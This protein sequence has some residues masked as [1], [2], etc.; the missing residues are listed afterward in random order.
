VVTLDPSLSPDQT[1]PLSPADQERLQTPG[2]YSEAVDVIGQTT[3]YVPNLPKAPGEKTEPLADENLEM[4]AEFAPALPVSPSV[5]EKAEVT[6]EPAGPATARDRPSGA[7]IYDVRRPRNEALGVLDRIGRFQIR[8]LLGEGAFGRVY[9]AYDPQLDREVALKVPK[10]SGDKDRAGQQQRF[11]REAQAAARLRHAGIVIVYDSGAAGADL[12]IACEYVEG[13]SLATVMAKGRPKIRRAAQWVRDMAKAL[14]Y[15]HRQ[16]LIHRDIKPGNI[17]IDQQGKPRLMDFGLAKRL[18]GTVAADQAGPASDDALWTRQGNI[19]GTPAYMA[20]EQAR[21][22]A[23]AVGRHSDQFSLGVV[24]YELLTGARPY[25]GGSVYEV[26]C[27]LVDPKAKP[28]RPRTLEPAIPP[29]LEAICLKALTREP[30]R[31][32][33]SCGDL[34]EDLSCWLAGKPVEAL[35]QG[36]LVRLREW[37]RRHRP[38]AIASG[39]AAASLLLIAMLVFGLTAYWRHL[40]GVARENEER[41]AELQ[42]QEKAQR[43]LA[44][45]AECQSLRQTG[46]TRCGNQRIPEG[47]LL[48]ARAFAKATEVADETL[49]RPV[50]GDLREWLGQLDEPAALKPLSRPGWAAVSRLLG[51]ALKPEAGAADDEDKIV[52]LLGIPLARERPVELACFSADGSNVLAATATSWRWWQAATG[53]S[54]GSVQEYRARALTPDGTKVLATNGAAEAPTLCLRDALSGEALGASFMGRSPNDTIY[55]SPDGGL[56]VIVPGEGFANL[57]NTVTGKHLE[58][59]LGKDWRLSGLAFSQDGQWLLGSWG[60]GAERLA[61]FWHSPDKK[62][63]GKPFPLA[64]D[65]PDISAMSLAP[66]G[67]TLMTAGGKEVWLWQ[68]TAD[69]GNLVAGRG[70]T[71]EPLGRPLVPTGKG[72]VRFA[73]LGPDGKCLVACAGDAVTFWESPTTKRTGESLSQE[74]AQGAAF[75]SN[76]TRLLTWGGRQARVWDTQTCRPIGLPLDHPAAISAAALSPDGQS[77]FLLGGGKLRV[78]PVESSRQDR[79]DGVRIWAELLTEME[80]DDQGEFHPLTRDS[81]SARRRQLEKIIGLLGGE[82]DPQGN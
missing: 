62:W 45:Q 7:E 15:A 60:R 73:T 26:L 74:A 12:F 21:G 35:P 75:D 77:A 3:D 16:G 68:L 52:R 25:T 61:K 17:M 41:L 47:V 59:P 4:V 8:A 5:T 80:V 18:D 53:K 9:R 51:V 19:V 32:Y 63:I 72:N 54:A 82:A 28:R 39:L 70:V 38:L 64:Q 37:Y 40:S 78:W 11:L 65:G 14:D 71:F 69:L 57:L 31:R 34:A 33:D 13:Q 10:L 42:R 46:L 30:G 23:S 58:T 2:N 24:L 50:G 76:G 79:S 43:V 29:E 55:L 44:L 67:K 48:L 1:A 81:W 49:E 66:D 56:V 20:P 22:D 27:R 6:N 36:R